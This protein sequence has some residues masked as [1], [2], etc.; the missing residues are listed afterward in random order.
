MLRFK[1]SK[2]VE[3][4]QATCETFLVVLSKLRELLN[5]ANLTAQAQVIETLVSLLELQRINEFLKLL[6][7]LD[8]WGGSG[9]VWEVYIEDVTLAQEFEIEIIKL[10]DL[11][12][13]TNVLAKGIKPI[14]KVL[15]NTL[16][17]R[18]KV[19]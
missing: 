6:N 17:D 19:N 12:E 2:D 1:K 16:N 14:R 10:I 9:A 3:F 18:N 13:K 8:M 7:G 11:M 5:K 4:T 15:R